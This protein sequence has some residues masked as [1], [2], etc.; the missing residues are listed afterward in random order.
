VG[1]PDVE[2]VITE[3][4]DVELDLSLEPSQQDFE[5]F[6]VSPVQAGY[7]G[8]PLVG[9]SSPFDLRR[10]SAALHNLEQLHPKDHTALPQQDDAPHCLQARMLALPRGPASPGTRAYGDAEEI[11]LSSVA[12][13][14]PPKP[15]KPEG[16]EPPPPLA[17]WS[18]KLS[19]QLAGGKVETLEFSAAED[20]SKR[21]DDF[22]TQHRLHDLFKSAL[23]E[24]AQNMA[25]GRRHEEFVDIA[26]C[27]F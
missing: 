24:R 9:E 8:N 23:L 10:L 11:S 18:F 5:Q 16:P 6:Q 7:S 17:P 19:V 13:H 15:V 12:V 4:T 21:V 26:D 14:A 1:E 3:R 27:L 20:L 25:A 2:S 22:I